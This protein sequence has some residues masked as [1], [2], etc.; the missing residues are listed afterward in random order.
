MK[1]PIIILK[2]CFS[3]LII[4]FVVIFIF[5]YIRKILICVF[6]PSNFLFYCTINA[7]YVYF[8]YFYIKSKLLK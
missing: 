2:S 7:F 3:L 1:T 8:F 4:T 6:I 5:N